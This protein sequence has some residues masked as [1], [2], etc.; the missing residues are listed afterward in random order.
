MK[1]FVFENSTID[2]DLV[3][4]KGKVIKFKTICCC[5]DTSANARIKSQL[6]DDHVM[7]NS[8]VLGKD[9]K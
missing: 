3:D 1:M 8:F 9:W 4:G 2:A 5:S 6:T 7:V